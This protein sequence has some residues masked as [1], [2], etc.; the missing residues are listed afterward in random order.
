MGFGVCEG[1]SRS[2]SFEVKRRGDLDVTTFPPSL[3]IT[4]IIHAIRCDRNVSRPAIEV[5][6][7]ARVN[8][9][10]LKAE[11]KRTDGTLRPAHLEVSAWSLTKITQT[12]LE[13]QLKTN[14]GSDG[15][16]LADRLVLSL[17]SERDD[18]V[19]RISGGVT[20]P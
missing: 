20:A 11:W 4:V 16:N 14:V 3:E 6:D 5:F 19:A 15:V 1:R 7:P 17:F 2:V 18:R 10:E 12:Q 8:S 13:W 9:F